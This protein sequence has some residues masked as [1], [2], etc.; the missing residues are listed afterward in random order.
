MFSR[1]WMPIAQVQ[2]VISLANRPHISLECQQG[3]LGGLLGSLETSDD[4]TIP[5]P[6]KRCLVLARC[7]LHDVGLELRLIGLI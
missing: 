7:G 5:S 4:L 1:F 3:L 6:R 2:L